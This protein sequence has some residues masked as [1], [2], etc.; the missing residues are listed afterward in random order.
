MNCKYSVQ[1]SSVYNPDGLIIID[2]GIQHC[3]AKKTRMVDNLK[4][5]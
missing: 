4:V 1:I 2:Q 3:D 5:I